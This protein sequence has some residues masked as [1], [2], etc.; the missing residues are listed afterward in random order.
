MDVVA[1]IN[2]LIK[3]LDEN[4]ERMMRGN[5]TK[6]Y[7]EQND[8][9]KINSIVSTMIMDLDNLFATIKE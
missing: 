2:Q 7:K 9:A 8:D 4:H 3:Q 6:F 5:E 1:E